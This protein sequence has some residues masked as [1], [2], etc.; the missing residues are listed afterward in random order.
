[1]AAVNFLFSHDDEGHF[2]QP[3]ILCVVTGWH[4]GLVAVVQV[5]CYLL[6]AVSRKHLRDTGHLQ[7]PAVATF[8]ILYKINM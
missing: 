1:M 6:V 4:N 2:I 5:L 7:E 3:I 8:V